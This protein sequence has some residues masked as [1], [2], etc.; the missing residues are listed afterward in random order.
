MRLCLLPLALAIAAPATAQIG[1][2]G[3]RQA[4]GTRDVESRFSPFSR[5]GSRREVA[6]AA[7]STARA[8]E[9]ERILMDYRRLRYASGGLTEAE[10]AMLEARARQL[11]AEVGRSYRYSSYENYE[12]RRRNGNGLHDQRTC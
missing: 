10:A 11:E 5:C 1:I 9:R 4:A 8:V 6:M 12:R 3:A 2:N 7:G